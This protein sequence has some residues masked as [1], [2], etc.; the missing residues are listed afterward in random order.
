MS[1]ESQ[2]AV[3]SG[4]TKAVLMRRRSH[5]SR[6]PQSAAERDENGNAAQRRKE[7]KVRL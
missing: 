2:P 1:P 4:G 3:H 7:G 6:G 5:C